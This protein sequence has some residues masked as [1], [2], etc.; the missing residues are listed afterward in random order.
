LQKGLKI[1]YINPSFRPVCW[2]DNW[3]T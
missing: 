1:A 2:K 3:T